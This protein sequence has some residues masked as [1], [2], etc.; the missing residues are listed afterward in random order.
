MSEYTIDKID[1]GGNTYKIDYSRMPY[2]TIDANSTS[3]IFN[4]T[5]DGITELS[6]GVYALIK[7]GVITS[8]SGCTLNVSELQITSFHQSGLYVQSSDVIVQLLLEQSHCLT[9]GALTR[10]QRGHSQPCSALG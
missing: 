6:D 8:A 5:V 3:T 9:Q 4:A 1:Y 2:G 7:N 10:P